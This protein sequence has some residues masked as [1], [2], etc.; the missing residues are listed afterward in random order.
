MAVILITLIEFLLCQYDDGEKC[1][2]VGQFS[3]Q[4][5]SAYGI[6]L[7]YDSCEIREKR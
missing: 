5:K 1:C 7:I 6:K 3:M 4:K 2:R